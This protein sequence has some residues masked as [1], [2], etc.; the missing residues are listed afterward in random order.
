MK[1]VY[2]PEYD[3]LNILLV[4]KP[5]SESREVVDNIVFDYDENGKIVGIEIEHANEMVDIKSLTPRM[6]V[7]YGIQEQKTA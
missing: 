4:D 5:S 1:V 2:H 6:E 3:M 7:F